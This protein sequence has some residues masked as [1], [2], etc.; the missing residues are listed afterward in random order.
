VDSIRKNRDRLATSR[1]RTSIFSR[2]NKTKNLT[3]MTKV[4]W[5]FQTLSDLEEIHAFH[6][7]KSLSYADF[8]IDEI[9]SVGDKLEK[10]PRLG[11]VVK[12]MNKK[13]IREVVVRDYRV[14]YSLPDLQIVKIL[15][16]HPC[17]IPL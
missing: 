6:E 5:T 14:I 11:K 17:K 3:L 1:I 8:L 12:E 10:F 4:N 13:S 16:V 7:K 9:L 15:T 2:R